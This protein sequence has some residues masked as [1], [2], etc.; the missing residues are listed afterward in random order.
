M[1][2]WLGREGIG[3]SRLEPDCL[4]YPVNHTDGKEV[5]VVL[6]AAADFGLGRQNLAD[7]TWSEPAEKGLATRPLIV[8]Q[9]EKVKKLSTQSVILISLTSERWLSWNCL[10]LEPLPLEKGDKKN[11]QKFK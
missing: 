2:W 6:A 7:K 10:S 11:E 1:I 3:F 9:N 8:E 4:V 5:I